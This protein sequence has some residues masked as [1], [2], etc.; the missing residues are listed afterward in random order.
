MAENHYEATISGMS[1]EIKQLAKIL[2]SLPDDVKARM[3]D[4]LERK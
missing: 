1:K 3:A 2:D 4:D